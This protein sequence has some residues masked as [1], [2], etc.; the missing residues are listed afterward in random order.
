MYEKAQWLEP[1]WP[2]PD[3]VRSLV[4][5]RRGGASSRCYASNN[6]GLHVGDEK[7]SVLHNRQQLNTRLPGEPCWLQQVHGTCVYE[8]G[9]ALPK[10]VP[11]ADACYTKTRRR[12]C[13]VMTADCLPVLLCSADAGEVAAVH[14]GWRGLAAGVVT[15]AVQRFECSPSMLFAYLGPAISALYFEVGADVKCAFRRAQD[16][17]P[18]ATAVE[19]AFTPS[20]EGKFYADL[21][22]LAH[23][24]LIGLGVSNVFSDDYCTFRDENQFFSF[25]RDGVTGRMAS[26]IWLD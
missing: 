9:D 10:Q 6:L 21:K 8:L 7:A 24:E 16:S 25:R 22:Q 2:V 12:V 14:A 1:N 20:A 17:R 18:Y 19:K 4:S 23:S 3:G 11:E 5:T 13:S 15:A 26:L